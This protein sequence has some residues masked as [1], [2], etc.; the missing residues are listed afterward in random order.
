MKKADRRQSKTKRKL[1]GKTS[2]KKPTSLAASGALVQGESS[3]RRD[4]WTKLERR[5]TTILLANK[6]ENTASNMR[7]DY[8][9]LSWRTRQ[10][11]QWI[12][13]TQQ[14]GEQ[15]TLEKARKDFWGSILVGDEERVPYL[16]D[17]ELEKQITVQQSPSDFAE[18]IVTRRW[19][20]EEST[21]ATYLHRKPGPKSPNN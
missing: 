1:T 7:K 2:P 15:P 18:E 10:L 12:T 13:Q 17:Q 9:L 3:P 8:D 21:G 19:G 11:S 6:D 14:Q 5:G 16:T 20:V 4:E